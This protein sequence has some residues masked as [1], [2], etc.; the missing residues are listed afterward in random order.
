MRDSEK[1]NCQTWGEHC[2]VGKKKTETRRES[3]NRQEISD[4]RGKHEQSGS[5]GRRGSENTSKVGHAVRIR[6]GG[7]LPAEQAKPC[8]QSG[9]KAAGGTG[10]FVRKRKS[11]RAQQKV[12]I[13]GQKTAPK[14]AEGVSCSWRFQLQK[15]FRRRKLHEAGTGHHAGRAHSDRQGLSGQWK[16]LQRDGLEVQ[17]ELPAG[18]KMDTEI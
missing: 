10:V 8:V 16:K 18:A 13:T 2:Y 4:R 14:L 11:G 17:G 12:W 6:R 9:I 3:K 1:T 7:S 5:R 15:E